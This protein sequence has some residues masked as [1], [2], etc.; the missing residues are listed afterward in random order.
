MKYRLIREARFKFFE[1][2]DDEYWQQRLDEQQ[3]EEYG[4][5][6]LNEY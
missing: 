6:R 5:G 2:A 4:S 1:R 3:Q